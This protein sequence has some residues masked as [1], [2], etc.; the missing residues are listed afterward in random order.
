MGFLP[1]PEGKKEGLA[2]SLGPPSAPPAGSTHTC[3]TLLIA[4]SP[5]LLGLSFLTCEMEVMVQAVQ[6]SCPLILGPLLSAGK[7]P[8]TPAPSTGWQTYQGPGRP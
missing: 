4:K 7:A 3:G 1:S 2:A 5:Y 8:C 6:S